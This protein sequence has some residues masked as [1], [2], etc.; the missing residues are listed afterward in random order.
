M[1]EK[2]RVLAEYIWIDGQ[3]P[4][5]KLRSKP[6]VLSIVNTLDDIPD[7]TFDGSSTF[8]AVTSPSD[9][10]LKPVRFIYDP[11]RGE[12]NVVV[13]CEVLNLDGTPHKSNTRARLRQAVEKHG[14]QDPWFGIEQEYTLYG[15]HDW[16]LGW[17]TE[18]VMLKK[19]NKSFKTILKK[20]LPPQGRYYCGV[21]YDEVHG[22]PLFEAHL[23]ACL[24]AGLGLYGGNAEVMPAQWEFQLGVLPPLEIT[25]QLWLARWLL[26][27]LGENYGAYA[28]LDPKPMSGDWNGAGAHINFSTKGIRENGLP[29]IEVACKKLGRFHK[30]HVAVY[31]VDNDKRLTGRHET[32]S[33][34]DFRYGEYDR[35]ASIRIPKVA[36]KAPDHLEDRRP[37]ANIDPYKACTALLETVCGK[38]FKPPKEWVELKI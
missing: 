27:R 22:R 19:G 16:P 30:E 23:D 15:Q 32:S 35:G 31:G 21:G 1:R 6:K 28:K 24:E 20:F 4:T 18:E 3:K 17:P 5:A 25:D 29:A 8:Q 9:C 37:A 33:I 13:L 12:P 38:G 11:V 34:R 14:D 26:Y 2:E 36:G 7:W 10:I